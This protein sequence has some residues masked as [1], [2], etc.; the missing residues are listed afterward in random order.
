MRAVELEIDVEDCE[1]LDEEQEAQEYSAPLVA[2]GV[3]RDEAPDESQDGREPEALEPE[4]RFEFDFVD[5]EE[6][7]ELEHPQLEHP[8]LDEEALDEEALGNVLL[9]PSDTVE[10]EDALRG[11]GLMD[12]RELEAQA[13][14][15]ASE[16]VF[17]LDAEPADESAFAFTAEAIVPE[18]AQA[19]EGAD[20]GETDEVDSL[21]D[22][23]LDGETLADGSLESAELELDADPEAAE[24]ESLE[25]FIDNDPDPLSVPV[26]ASA[27]ALRYAFARGLRGMAQSPLVQLLAV[28]TMAVC[29]LLLGTATLMFQNANAVATTLGI[30][31]PVTVFMDPEADPAETMAL[32]ARLQALPEVAHAERVTPEQAMAR[33][34]DGLGEGLAGTQD[35][36]HAAGEAGG[37]LEGVDPSTLPDTIELS[38]GE[39][40]EPGFADALALRVQDM[41]GVEEVSVL[42]PWVQQAEDMLTTLRWLAVG[43]GVLVSL[44][45]LAIV[46]STIR[47]GVFARRAELQILRL[48]GGTARFVRGP[49][50]V[51]GVLQ[52]VLGTALALAALYLGFEL[53][54]PFLERGLALVFAA[55]SLRFFSVVEVSAALG[56]GAL[57]GLIGARAAV[58]RHAEV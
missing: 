35:H 25:A 45:C 17:D 44:A 50:M 51:E 11:S 28:G 58:A 36:G 42:G 3:I 40:V 16:P 8:Q 49:F 39:G 46:W 7:E 43:V 27:N 56:L 29:M 12:L 31:V 48:V 21:D 57:L 18:P 41:E 37:L 24:D 53:I 9:E 34:Q 22:E 52:G 54:R 38:L 26:W 6:P 1:V 15:A 33:L 55:G 23:S 47:L 30:E 19:L 13:H 10:L 32:T 4:L 14:A 20:A 2:L 5:D